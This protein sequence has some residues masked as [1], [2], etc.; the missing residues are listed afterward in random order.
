MFFVNLVSVVS[1]ASVVSLVCLVVRCV[2]SIVVSMICVLSDLIIVSVLFET[3]LVCAMSKSSVVLF[4]FDVSI[5]VRFDC[6]FCFVWSF[7][8][9]CSVCN[10]WSVFECNVFCVYFYICYMLGAN[11]VGSSSSF[12]YFWSYWRV[13]IMWSSVCFWNWIQ[14]TFIL[15]TSNFGVILENRLS[16]MWVLITWFALNKLTKLFVRVCIAVFKMLFLLRS[17]TADRTKENM[18]FSFCFFTLYL[19]RK[20]H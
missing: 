12:Y 13:S 15:N 7:C 6:S 2:L 8:S 10:F 20:L 3:S 9:V 18:S 16:K 5:V 11:C 14:F 19:N 1:E 4:S 17:E